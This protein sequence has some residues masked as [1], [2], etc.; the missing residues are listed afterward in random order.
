MANLCRKGKKLAPEQDATGM[1]FLD[2]KWQVWKFGG[3]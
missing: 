3:A 2:Q 1:L